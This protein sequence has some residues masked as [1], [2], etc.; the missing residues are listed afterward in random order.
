M[1]ETILR[2]PGGTRPQRYMA[3]RLALVTTILALLHHIDHVLRFDHSGWPFTPQV[4]PFTFS[5][6]VY[7]VIALILLLRRA[8]RV[9]AALAMAL[10]LFATLAHI[11][12]ETPFDQ[13]A[14]WAHA[15]D[16]NLLRAESPL[17]GAIAVAITVL[18]SVFALATA[19]AYALDAGREARS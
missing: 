9:Q 2:R 18:L 10:F 6:L 7:V 14:T 5:L 12:L 16:V 1:C 11:F 17:L 8:P 19:I 15:P 3:A 4:T 13:Y